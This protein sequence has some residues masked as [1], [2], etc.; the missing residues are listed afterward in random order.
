MNLSYCDYIAHLIKQSLLT[1]DNMK[2]I[3]KVNGVKY[4]LDENG[5]FLSTKKTIEVIDLNKSCYRITIEDVAP[6]QSV[7]DET[8]ESLVQ[9]FI[10]GED[11]TDQP[12]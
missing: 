12:V 6:V 5:V 2:L 11:G 4:D 1:T 10:E 8:L 7:G 3:Q 9:D